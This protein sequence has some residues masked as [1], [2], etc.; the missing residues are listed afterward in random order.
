M[1]WLPSLG[2]GRYQ[3]SSS[4]LWKIHQAVSIFTFRSPG[5]LEKFES[6]IKIKNVNDTNDN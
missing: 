5:T 2:V 3:V 6:F 1:R 4:Q